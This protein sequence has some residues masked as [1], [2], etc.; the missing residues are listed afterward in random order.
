M[1]AYG[2]YPRPVTQQT[3]SPTSILARQYQRSL[4]TPEV[5]I[6]PAHFNRAGIMSRRTFAAFNVGKLIAGVNGNP[7]LPAGFNA[8]A[9]NLTRLANTTD[10]SIANAYNL[11]RDGIDVDLRRFRPAYYGSSFHDPGSIYPNYYPY[12]P[13]ARGSYSRSC[14]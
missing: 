6:T 10:N 1:Y 3:E 7:L 2:A 9:F 4:Q 12:R 5:L 8:G 14:S 11:D 13:Y